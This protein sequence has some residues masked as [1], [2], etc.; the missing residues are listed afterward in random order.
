MEAIPLNHIFTT[1]Y[2]DSVQLEKPIAN[3]AHLGL[4][5]IYIMLVKREIVSI[6]FLLLSLFLVFQ[7]IFP[8]IGGTATLA[9]KQTQ[10]LLS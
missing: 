4:H 10:K 3:L 5:P 6:L 1:P 9:I 7:Y 2:D 8:F